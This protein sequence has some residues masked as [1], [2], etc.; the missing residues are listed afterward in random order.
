M[1][2]TSVELLSTR[3]SCVHTGKP[4][5]DS[6]TYNTSLS[7]DTPPKMAWNILHSIVPNGFKLSCIIR[8]DGGNNYAF[9]VERSGANKQEQWCNPPDEYTVTVDLAEYAE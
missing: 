6:V 4:Y 8:E 5:P 9:S 7:G 3:I 2:S 1:S